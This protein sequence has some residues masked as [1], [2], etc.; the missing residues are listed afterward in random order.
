VSVQLNFSELV[1]FAIN[2]N[3]VPLIKIQP[4]HASQFAET[5]KFT[6]HPPPSVNAESVS[7]S[8][9]EDVEPAHPITFMKPQSKT[10]FQSAE[11][12]KSTLS[13]REDAFVQKAFTWSKAYVTN[14][15]TIEFT[16]FL[17]KF[18]DQDAN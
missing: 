18:A 2:A 16:K 4:D 6:T 5:T 14:A 11:P 17:F 10:A 15:A 7:T 8:S 12:T 1:L 9:K 3:Q 13:L